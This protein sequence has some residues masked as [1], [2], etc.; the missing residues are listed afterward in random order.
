MRGA[1]ADEEYAAND[2][3]ENEFMLGDS[4]RL[5][6]VAERHDYSAKKQRK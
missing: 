6:Q 2:N 3:A 5:I 4:E 1:V